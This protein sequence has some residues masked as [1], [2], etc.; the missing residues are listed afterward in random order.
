MSTA[1]TPHPDGR[2]TAVNRSLLR[3]G[4]CIGLGA[5]TTVTIAWALALRGGRRS[6][7]VVPAKAWGSKQDAEAIVLFA[8]F[9]WPGE[10][11]PGMTA[12]RFERG[13]REVIASEILPER[14][15]EGDVPQIYPID[16][17]P[18]LEC[19]LPLECNPPPAGVA[20]RDE[21]QFGWPLR[22]MWAADDRY[23]P[24]RDTQDLDWTKT[25][26][27]WPLI[28]SDA[29]GASSLDSLDVATLSSLL[30]EYER[31]NG[32]SGRQNWYLPTGVLWRGMAINTTAYACAWWLLLFATGTARRSFRRR[33]GLCLLCGYPTGASP[34]CTECGNPVRPKAAAPA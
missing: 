8:P 3:V 7:S 32:F 12:L 26:R 22:A 18:P 14:L 33:R 16:V 1:A 20:G 23:P 25:V 2:R 10:A 21:F 30:R 19:E 17:G 4:L 27:V 11:R 34:V 15:P 31:F 28:K 24:G 5:F 29:T 13:P 6:S 9:P